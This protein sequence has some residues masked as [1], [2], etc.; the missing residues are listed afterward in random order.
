MAWEV[1]A[2]DEFTEWYDALAKGVA[3]YVTAAIDQLEENGPNL[4]FPK[5]SK[6]MKSRHANMRELRVQ[7]AGRPYRI[8]YAFDPRRTAILLIGGEKTG[9]NRW[10]DVYV[11]RAD[12]LYDVYLGEIRKEGLI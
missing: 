3:H 2:T 7:A 6:V 4:D 1:E 9:K 8:L 11:P 12:K 5:S 10:Y